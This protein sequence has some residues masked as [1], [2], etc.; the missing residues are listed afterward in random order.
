MSHLDISFVKY[1]SGNKDL[2]LN[3]HWD[4][5]SVASAKSFIS[6]QMNHLS[7]KGKY[8][9]GFKIYQAPCMTNF[10]FTAGMPS[11]VNPPTVKIPFRPS[12]KVTS[13]HPCEKSG[14]GSVCSCT[15]HSAVLASNTCTTFDSRSAIFEEVKAYLNKSF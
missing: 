14:L 13:L 15:F 1:L 3:F 11:V 9:Q 5:A 4:Q 6:N 7:T 12:F 8:V 2:S 10:N